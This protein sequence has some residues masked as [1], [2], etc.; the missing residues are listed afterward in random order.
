MQPRRHVLPKK[1]IVLAGLLSLG[2]G[3]LAARYALRPSGQAGGVDSSAPPGFTVRNV[4]GDGNCFYYA[5]AQTMD[6]TWDSER[7][8]EFKRQLLVWLDQHPTCD[9][10][11]AQ[12]AHEPSVRDRLLSEF[13]WAQ[14]SEIQLASEQLDRCIYVFK[15]RAPGQWT[16]SLSLPHRMRGRIQNDTCLHEGRAVDHLQEELYCPECNGKSS[17]L[18]NL[19]GGPLDEGQHFVALIPSPSRL[20]HVVRTSPS[21]DRTAA[22][23]ASSPSPS[24]PSGAS[25]ASHAQRRSPAPHRGTEGSSSRLPSSRRGGVAHSPSS[26]RD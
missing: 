22:S 13:A 20:G 23:R 11:L 21:Y 17:F 19:A 18:L 9:V 16:L 10:A 14:Q 4:S 12:M 2:L 7:V 15:T 1:H 24:L 26:S 3:T 5:L 6:Q 8:S 25:P